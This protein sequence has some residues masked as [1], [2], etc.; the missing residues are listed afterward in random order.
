MSIKSKINLISNGDYF[1]Y[2]VSPYTDILGPWF[3]AIVFWIFVIM[4]YM[5]TQSVELPLIISCLGAA[6]FIFLLPVGIGAFVA[7]AMACAAAA[8]MVRLFKEN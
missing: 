1:G 6:A 2:I 8:I 3:Y 7:V 4:V 5:K